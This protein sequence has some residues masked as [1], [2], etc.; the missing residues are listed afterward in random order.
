MALDDFATSPSPGEEL[1][2]EVRHR[3]ISETGYECRQPVAE[4]Y[5]GNQWELSGVVL[6]DDKTPKG[7]FIVPSL[8]ASPSPAT[9][10]SELEHAFVIAAEFR[11]EQVPGAV[12]VPN[13]QPDSETD[14]EQLFESIECELIEESE[15]DEFIDAL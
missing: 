13:K 3:I 14:W 1:S 11:K 8:A 2:T 9:Y 6:D 12:I 7:Y 10:E 5:S 4:G 15:L